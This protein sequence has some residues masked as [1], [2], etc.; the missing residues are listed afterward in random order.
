MYFSTPIKASTHIFKPSSKLVDEL[1]QNEYY[2]M[3]LA[4]AVGINVPSTNIQTIGNTPVFRIKRYDRELIENEVVRLHQEDFCQA[5]NVVPE[6]KYQS[7]GG[8]S[9]DDCI[10]LL[11]SHSIQPSKAVSYTHLTLPTIYSV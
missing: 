10:Q 1:V 4:A 3:Q 8:P 2:C 9:I 6:N 7:E 5:L 11:L